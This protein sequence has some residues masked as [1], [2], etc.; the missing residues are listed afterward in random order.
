MWDEVSKK[1]FIIGTNP[2]SRL[3]IWWDGSEP[4]WVTLQKLGR[5]VFMYYWPGTINVQLYLKLSV[6]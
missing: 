2:D 4:L 6:C 5:K 3:P 1:E